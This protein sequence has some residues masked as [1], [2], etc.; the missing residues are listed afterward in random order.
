MITVMLCVVAALWIRSIFWCDSIWWSDGSHCITLVSSGGKLNLTHAYW[1]T[2]NSP[3]LRWRSWRRG[4]KVAPVFDYIPWEHPEVFARHRFLGFEHSPD[5]RC[6][7]GPWG[8][9]NTSLYWFTYSLT[10]VPY[11]SP[12]LITAFPLTVRLVRNRKRRRRHRE[13]RCLHCGYDL[14]SS[15]GRCP[16]CGAEPASDSTVSVIDTSRRGTVA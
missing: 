7:G 10:A 3:E 12:V 6:G 8:G 2:H 16:E 15:P 13:G 14:R 5:M 11:W 4:T 9:Y 1:P